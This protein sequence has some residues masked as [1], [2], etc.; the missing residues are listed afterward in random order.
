M[1]NNNTL[2]YRVGELEIECNKMDIK[3]EAIMEN[4]LPHIQNELRGLKTLA[5]LNVFAIILGVLIAKYL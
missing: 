1:T 5:T 4:H 2:K 3:L